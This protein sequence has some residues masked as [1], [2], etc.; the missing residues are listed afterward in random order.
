MELNSNDFST[1]DLGPAEL[2]AGFGPIMQ[3]VVQSSRTMRQQVFEIVRGSGNISRA[4]I[5]RQLNVSPASVT[6][7]TS[8]LIERGLIEEVAIERPEGD[9]GRGRPP[10]ALKVR[11]GTHFVAGLKFSE[12]VHTA[13]ILDFAGN[14]VADFELA[15]SPGRVSPDDLLDVL[16]R[17]LNGVLNAAG[18]ERSALAAVGVGIPGFV[19]NASGIVAWSP[20]LQ[21]RNVDLV[22][23]AEARLGLNVFVDNDAHILTLAELWFGAGRELSNF[24]VITIEHGVGMGVV[25]NHAL[26]RGAEGIGMEL[27]HTKVQLDG[28]LCRCGQRGCLEAYIADYALVREAHIALEWNTNK[29]VPHSE[30]LQELFEQAK[31]GQGAARTIF[32]RAG[33]YLAVGLANV[34]NIFDPSLVILSGERMQYDY[35]YASDTMAELR[36]M[37]IAS[38]RPL[39]PLKVNAWG[40]LVWANGAAALALDCMTDRMLGAQREVVEA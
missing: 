15:V 20:M 40:D 23:L 38:G 1:V 27:G 4:N 10:I 30:L 2:S 35:L 26:Y 21:D 19:E 33:R 3:R 39:P 34:I 6:A 17:V 32:R 9:S 14:H 7:T 18:L 29:S 16:E 31:S 13:V 24:A 25:I 28:A 5:A 36:D 8:E 12:R 11:A 37:V 22:G